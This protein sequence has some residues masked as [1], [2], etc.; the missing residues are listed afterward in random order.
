MAH[1]AIVHPSS[2]WQKLVPLLVGIA[3]PI[4]A[5]R[6][7]QVLGLASEAGIVI[8]AV[9]LFLIG[10]IAASWISPG[11]LWA[12]G[13]LLLAGVP[14][15]TLVDVIVDWFVFSHDRNMFPFEIVQWWILGAIPVALGVMW[16]RS[17]REEY[18][19]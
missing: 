3:I 13:L 11:R 8:A 17:L 1:A 4:A 10:G 12:V 9:I 19:K 14:I 18:A 2:P 5:Y 15:G 6:L 16:G 7:P